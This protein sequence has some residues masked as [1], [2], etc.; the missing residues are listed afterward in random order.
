LPIGR[1]PVARSRVERALEV[2][3]LVVG[4]GRSGVAAAEETAPAGSR[5]VLLEAAI[6][7]AQPRH[8]D[9]RFLEG[10]AA[11]GWYDGV[12]TAIDDSTL[13]SIR[14]GSV[15]VATGSYERVPP[16]RGADSPGVIGARRVAD[17]ITHHGVLPGERA[18]LVGEEADLAAA[19]AALERGG[20]RIVAA[21]P[22]SALRR[23]LG[24]RHVIGAVVE[25]DGAERRL[26]IDLVVIGDRTPNLDLVLAAGAAV[27][28]R[29]GVLVP[30]L[31]EAGRTSIPGLSVVGSAA[32]HRASASAPTPTGRALVCFCEDV[33]AD[34][35]EAQVVAGYGDPE[36]VKRRTGAL[37]GPCQGK[38]CL[39]AF[40][41]VLAAAGV[42][43]SAAQGDL[44]TA[45]PPLRPLRLG[46]L[47]ATEEMADP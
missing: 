33:H 43:G 19:R 6:G 39:Q 9:I 41:A 34:E 13:W 3:V 15:I 4:G 21:V 27:E 17:L 47:V 26:A 8:P 36:L 2:D 1:P 18:M 45:R 40:S 46:D 20:A 10:A 44:P 14:A 35:I 11:V 24:R 28:R 37:T 23:V 31:D 22:T 16:V 42:E 29:D 5:V 38:Y 25:H 32:G 12:V 30:V 7:R